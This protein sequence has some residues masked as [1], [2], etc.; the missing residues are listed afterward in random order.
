MQTTNAKGTGMRHIATGVSVRSNT[1]TSAP[2]A[3]HASKAVAVR[4]QASGIN[5]PSQRDDPERDAA[6]KAAI[7]GPL[8]AMT[9]MHLSSAQDAKEALAFW[10]D[11]LRPYHVEQIKAA[12]LF[13]ARSGGGKYPSPQ[14]IIATIEKLK[15][16]K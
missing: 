4:N 8:T 9:A 15:A 5:L 1:G 3:E 2:K 10:V 12:F 16:R 14:A 7:R 13:F 11:A 6:I